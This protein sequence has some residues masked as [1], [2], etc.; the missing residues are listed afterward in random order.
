MAP[1]RQ[2]V[3]AGRFYPADRQQCVQMLD[4]MMRPVVDV[5]GQVVGA[6]VPHAGWV[7]SGPTAALAIAA[8]AS[9]NP[10]TAVI[11]GAVHVFDLNPAS[12]Y[13]SGSWVT[14]LGPL[15]VDEELAQRVA[16]HPGIAANPDA[17]EHEHS[18]EVQLPLI[19]HILGDVRILP[20][21]VTPGPNAAEIGRLVAQEV[22]AMNRRVVFLA[23]TDLTHYGG[24]FGFEPHGHG[25]DG[26]RWA[27]EV[28]DRR[29]IDLIVA[30][31]ADAIVPE[32][33]ANHNACGAGA[34]AAMIAAAK[35]AG[36]DRYIELEHTTSA[37]R[38]L[39]D[40]S[41]SASSVGYEAGVFTRSG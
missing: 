7:Y 29:F 32:A 36:A 16:S 18:I 26:I 22:P 34:V 8:V 2:P 17:H 28:N 15:Q 23:S 40:W 14:P 27:K 13:P 33:T 20:I 30:M 24:M 39:G 25:M 41:P 3:V 38:D 10:E 12:V 6:V 9:A 19:Q 31:D 11:F 1:V 37:D 21:M 4:D 5:Q 35:E